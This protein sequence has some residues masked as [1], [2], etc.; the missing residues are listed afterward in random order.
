[1]QPGLFDPFVSELRRQEGMASAR[2]N[3]DVDWRKQVEDAV[4]WLAG[5]KAP[6]TADDVRK[7]VGDP[8]TGTHYNAMGA[9]IAGLAKAGI[10]HPIGYT[11]SA[12]VVGHS[13][14]VRRWMG[15]A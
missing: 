9:I 5:T 10:I 11:K 4:I 13:N 14:L 8:P 15:T 6:F 1:M 7:Q 12:R 3:A 2:Q